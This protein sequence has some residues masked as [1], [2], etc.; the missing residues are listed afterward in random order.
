[1]ATLM[2]FI[3]G[4]HTE[5]VVIREAASRESIIED[6]GPAYE[7]VDEI[8]IDGDVTGFPCDRFLG[9]VDAG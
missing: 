1:M 6:A 4:G 3:K 2:H 7:L 8:E 5:L 9:D